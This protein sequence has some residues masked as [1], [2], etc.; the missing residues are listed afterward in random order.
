M[1][2]LTLIPETVATSKITHKPPE[3]HFSLTIHFLTT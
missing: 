3:Q 2:M 1:T